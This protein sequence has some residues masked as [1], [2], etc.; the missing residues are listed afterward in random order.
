M[1]HQNNNEFIITYFDEV[2]STNDLAFELVEDNKARNYHIITANCQTNGKGRRDREWISPKG[3]LYYSLILQFDK[4]KT[5]TDYSFLSACAIGKAL[6]SYGIKT[7]YKWPNDI[8]LNDKKLAGILLQFKSINNVA[9]LVVGIGLNLVLAPSYATSLKE[10]NI[11][12]EDFLEKF[13]EAFSYFDKKYQQF[14]FSIIRNEWKQYAY[15]IN[16]E[17]KLSNGMKGVFDDLDK[18]GN[19]LLKENNKIHKI[20]SEEII[21]N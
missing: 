18:D 10:H 14:G 1:Y 11:S 2:K 6:M 17:I 13:Q 15:Q 9:T 16:Q 3:N 20:L 12:K 4:L 21:M 8:I 5:I 7:Q 19:L